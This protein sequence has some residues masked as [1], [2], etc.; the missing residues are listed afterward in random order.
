MKPGRETPGVWASRGEE[1]QGLWEQGHTLQAIATRVGVSRERIRQLLLKRCRVRGRPPKFKT[2]HAVARL[3]GC[4]EGRL[5]R[6]ERGGR[7]API[8]YQNEGL[9]LYPP[10][11]VERAAVVLAKRRDGRPVVL[12]VCRTCGRQFRRKVYDI[13]PTSPANFC[14]R[15]CAGV[16]LG[17]QYG[18]HAHPENAV[19]GHPRKHDYD[20]I[21]RLK[22][23][24]GW[25]ARRI[26]RELGIPRSSVSAILQRLRR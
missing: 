12:Q 4:S 6:L 19:L 23:E 22:L 26:A 25:G 7:L 21:R 3:L 18:F 1:I 16:W 20:A 24:R 10:E 9:F 15:Y 8:H 11:M 14:S 17:R 5:E 2:R 13:R